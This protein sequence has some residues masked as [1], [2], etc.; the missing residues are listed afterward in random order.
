MSSLGG[1]NP[2]SPPLAMLGIE[3]KALTLLGRCYITELYL[4]ALGLL[5]HGLAALFRLT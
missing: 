1:G 4:L 5:W 3:P 2:L